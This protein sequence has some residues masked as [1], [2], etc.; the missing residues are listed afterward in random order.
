MCADTHVHLLVCIISGFP[1][2]VMEPALFSPLSL[3]FPAELP[4]T[5]GFIR[6]SSNTYLLSSDSVL[7]GFMCFSANNSK[8]YV[9][10]PPSCQWGP[11]INLMSP[12]QQLSMSS[13]EMG[14][15]SGGRGLELRLSLLSS[16]TVKGFDICMSVL[17]LWQSWSCSACIHLPLAPSDQRHLGSGCG[18]FCSI[19]IQYGLPAP[20]LALLRDTIRAEM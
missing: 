4:S 2:R 18:M 5:V 15:E 11:E 14:I 6:D 16:I 12:H 19:G 1:R 9:T 17:S 13:F 3:T 20:P 10:L 7:D 8:G